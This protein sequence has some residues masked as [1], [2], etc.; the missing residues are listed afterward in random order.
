M[1]TEAKCYSAGFEGGERDHKLRNVPLEVK[2]KETNS[3]GR[4]YPSE[5]S[6]FCPTELLEN[7]LF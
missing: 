3:S 6:D 1:I 5:T 4:F 2:G 7:N